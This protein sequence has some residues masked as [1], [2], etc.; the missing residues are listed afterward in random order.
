MCSKEAKK[1][2][3]NMIV[4]PHL[5]YAPTCWNPYTKCNIDKLEAVQCRAAKFVLSFYDYRPTADLILKSPKNYNGIHCNAVELL[6]IS[7]CSIN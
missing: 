1:S 7:A 6:Q 3:Y 5:E 2:A 4:H